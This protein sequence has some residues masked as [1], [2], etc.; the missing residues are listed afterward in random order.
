MLEADDR[1]VVEIIQQ[2]DAHASVWPNVYVTSDGVHPLEP[3]DAALHLGHGPRSQEH[4]SRI[5]IED[6]DLVA[7]AAHGRDLHGHRAGCPIT[8]R[9]DVLIG[10]RL[11][12]PLPNKSVLQNASIVHACR[13][14]DI[15]LGHGCYGGADA[16]RQW[17]ERGWISS[18]RAWS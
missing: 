1:C 6:A 18:S 12:P 15:T 17:G 13:A 16:G 14:D 3:G 8:M 11:P 7:G 5:R 4:L 2:D 10:H 9:G